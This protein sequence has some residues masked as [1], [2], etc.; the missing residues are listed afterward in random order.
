MYWL[1][2]KVFWFVFLNNIY[3]DLF[4]IDNF[5]KTIIEYRHQALEPIILN[6]KNFFTIK[7][8]HSSC[9]DYIYRLFYIHGYERLVKY[10]LIFIL[11]SSSKLNSFIESIPKS[12]KNRRCHIHSLDKIKSIQ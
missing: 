11:F 3:F 1:S 10:L 5:I 8:S 4:S 12:K 2:N 6:E 7:K 9:P